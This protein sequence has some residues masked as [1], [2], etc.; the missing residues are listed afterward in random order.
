MPTIAASVS[1][2]VMARKESNAAPTD[3]IN[4]RLK[5]STIERMEAFKERHHLRPAL[6]QIVEAAVR[7]YLDAQEPLLPP[8]PR[9]K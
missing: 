6:T 4:F 3:Q 1:F 9:G 5:V 8:K 2:P 7:E